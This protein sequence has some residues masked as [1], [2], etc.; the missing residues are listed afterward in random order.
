MYLVTS[1]YTYNM[2]NFIRYKKDLNSN[3]I[4]FSMLNNQYIKIVFTNLEALNTFVINFNN[5]TIIYYNVNTQSSR[6]NNH[7]L[8]VS[9]F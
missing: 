2:D 9:V 3:S 4:I 8:S 7:I 6:Q 1:D 5:K